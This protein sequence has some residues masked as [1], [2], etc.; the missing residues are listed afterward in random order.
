MCMGGVEP[1]EEDGVLKINLHITERAGHGVCGILKQ[2]PAKRC[3]VQVSH[4]NSYTPNIAALKP[5][6]VS[7][8]AFGVH[9]EQWTLT[10]LSSSV[11]ILLAWGLSSTA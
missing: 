7:M 2:E 8:S 10:S 1:L 5:V 6:N 3:L 11:G 9:Y 4:H